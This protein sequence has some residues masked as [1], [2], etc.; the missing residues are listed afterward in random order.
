MKTKVEKIQAKITFWS[1]YLKT[2]QRRYN[3]AHM[4]K[5][6]KARMSAIGDKILQLR[7]EEIEIITKNKSL[8]KRKMGLIENILHQIEYHKCEKEKIVRKYYETG[9]DLGFG[10]VLHHQ[11]EML[12][13]TEELHFELLKPNWEKLTMSDKVLL[14]T[15]YEM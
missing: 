11:R 13:L 14:N 4:N 2:H 10:M 1:L 8:Y 7:E 15:S 5:A 9:E 6:W 3:S 12:L